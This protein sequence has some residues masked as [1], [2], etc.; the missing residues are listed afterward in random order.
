MSC[1]YS[2]VSVRD[3]N[4]KSIVIF[5][6]SPL[7]FISFPST[8]NVVS[9][10]L[11]GLIKRGPGSRRT[12]KTGSSI[13][14]RLLPIDTRPSMCLP[15][16]FCFTPSNPFLEKYLSYTFFKSIP[17]S[18]ATHMAVRAVCW[19]SRI[20]AVADYLIVSQLMYF[21]VNPFFRGKI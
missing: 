4:K 9:A 11:M 2:A 21:S 14:N 8:Q 7:L 3:R 16:A 15:R 18:L 5:H 6:D 1:Q 10:A 12:L 13:H 17:P 20:V 19:E